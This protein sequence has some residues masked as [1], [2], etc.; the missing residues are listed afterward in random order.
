[1]RQLLIALLLAGCAKRSPAWSDPSLVDEVDAVEAQ[2][3][4]TILLDATTSDDPTP[5]SRA[6]TLLLRTAEPEKVT[7]FA[8]IALADADVWVQRAGVLALAERLDAPGAEQALVA[9]ATRSDAPPTT[10][11]LAAERLVGTAELADTLGAAWRTASEP[12]DIAPLAFAAALHGDE[13]ALGALAEALATGELDLDVDFLDRLGGS[14][15]DLSDALR[16]G[17]ER[18]EEELELPYAAA[19]LQL[20]DAAGEQAFRRTLSDDYVL[21]RLEAIDY[22]LDLDHPA[23]AG[24]LKRARGAGPEVVSQYA[25]LA[26]LAHDVGTSTTLE[27]GYEQSEREVRLAAVMVAERLLRSGSADRKV[28][29]AARRV[30]ESAA[31]DEASEVRAAAFAASGEQGT[32]DMPFEQGIRDE[33]HAVR[34][35]A[36]GALLSREA[37]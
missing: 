6:L 24:L 8:A 3:P 29:R 28:A 19:R 18:V 12:W 11:G 33:V 26:L 34:I 16:S 27:E 2:A 23:S 31:V 36:A 17:Q 37:G 21:R 20:G 30:V 5:R 1:M 7:T 13:D 9:Y 25:E 10:R 32:V 15:L 4:E 35:E 14:G 22:L